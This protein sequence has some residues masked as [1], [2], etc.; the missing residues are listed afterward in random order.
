MMYIELGYFALTLILISQHVKKKL[1]PRAKI[2]KL[3]S[4]LV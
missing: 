4:L 1:G 2:L 3:N